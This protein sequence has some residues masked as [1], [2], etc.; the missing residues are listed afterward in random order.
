MLATFSLKM[1]GPCGVRPSFL[2]GLCY[3]LIFG[4]PFGL[5]FGRFGARLW[6]F[7]LGLGG[8]AWLAQFW[9]EVGHLAAKAYT[10]WAGGVTRSV[11]N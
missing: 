3:F 7:S 4:P 8:L 1:G 11:K 9:C 6:K 5:D 2:L 10:G